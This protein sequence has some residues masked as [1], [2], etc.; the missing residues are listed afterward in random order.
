ML[1]AISSCHESFQVSYKQRNGL[2]RDEYVG[3]H[4]GNEGAYV[5]EFI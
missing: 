5:A 3:A 4:N 2:Q 1:G